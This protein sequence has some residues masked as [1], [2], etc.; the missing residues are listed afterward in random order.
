M[1]QKSM[2]EKRH[3]E[4]ALLVSDEELQRVFAGTNFGNACHREILAETLLKIAGDFSTGSTAMAC[5]QELGL[6]GQNR[7]NRRLTKK[8]R[9]YLYYAWSG[10][11]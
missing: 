10:R 8:G 3:G 7:I 9:R 2:S 1:E 6:L 5:C 4:L 11:Q